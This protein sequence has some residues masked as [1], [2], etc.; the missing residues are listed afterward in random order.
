MS[1]VGRKSFKDKVSEAVTPEDQKSYA[2]Q[3]KEFVTD[4]ID[5]VQSKLQ[6]EGA[7]SSTQQLGDAIQEGHDEAKSGGESFVEQV[8]HSINDAAEYV[9]GAFT[10]AKEGAKEGAEAASK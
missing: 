3:G 9:S 4:S 8:K 7:K 2:Q 1:D 10:G 6:P 5:K